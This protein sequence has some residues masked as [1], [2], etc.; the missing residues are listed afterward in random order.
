MFDFFRDVFDVPAEVDMY[1]SFWGIF[2][3]FFSFLAASFF[4]KRARQIN[5][6]SKGD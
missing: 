2:I 1:G 6:E 5:R 4:V 3:L